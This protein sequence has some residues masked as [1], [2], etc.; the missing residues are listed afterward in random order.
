VA[1]LTARRPLDM[2]TLGPVPAAPVRVS[3][4]TVTITGGGLTETY[5]GSFGPSDSPITGTIRSFSRSQGGTELF[6]V[7][8]IGRSAGT[9]FGILATDGFGPALDVIL[10]GNDTLRGSSG[11]DRLFA[12]DGHDQMVGNG[13]ADALFAGRGNDTV[14][15]GNGND[16]LY[17]EAARDRLFG[18]GGSDTLFAGDADDSLQGGTGNDTLYGEAGNDS[19]A[20]DGGRDTIFGSNGRDRMTG[21][22]GADRLY[23]EAADDSIAGNGG[24]DDMLGGTG[25]DTLRGGDGADT[26]YGEAGQ[27]Q[28]FGDA[29]D[30]ALFGSL[31]NDSLRGGEGRDTLFGDDGA[32]VIIGGAGADILAGGAQPDRFVFATVAEIG[33]GASADRI[34]DHDG[35]SDLIDL[36]AIDANTAMPGNQTFRFVGTDAFTGAA[37]ELRYVG[38]L[39][40]GDVDGDRLADFQLRIGNLILLEP[41]DFIL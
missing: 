27:D 20:G 26:L 18:D 17:G 5:L 22:D 15:G 28:L 40:S 16:S 34:A 32:D 7:D 41:G 9:Y 30:D 35:R 14:R 4:G 19:L 6:A 33:T 21:G 12:R 25:N 23:G 39:V 37:G 2:E 11:A 29:G 3:A 36:S 38:G 31:G 10:S 1:I 8:A 24:N 13:G